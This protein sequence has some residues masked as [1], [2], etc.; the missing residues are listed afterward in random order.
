MIGTKQRNA[1][2]TSFFISVDAKSD[3]LS[4]LTLTILLISSVTADILSLEINRFFI[5]SRS[6]DDTVGFSDFILSLGLCCLF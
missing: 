1:S 5:F 4:L 6:C 2:P 3:T